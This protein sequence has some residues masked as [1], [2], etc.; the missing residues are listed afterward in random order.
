MFYRYYIQSNGLSAIFGSQNMPAAQVT[1]ELEKDM[2]KI[3]SSGFD[4]VKLS[5]SFQ[6]NKA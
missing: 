2:E 6:A 3:K 4:G 5:Y 1:T